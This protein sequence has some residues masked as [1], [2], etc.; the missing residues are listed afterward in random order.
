MIPRTA[1]GA[2]REGLGSAPRVCRK[3]NVRSQVKQCDGED[4][5]VRNNSVER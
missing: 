5:K 1:L 4:W 3:R 2:H